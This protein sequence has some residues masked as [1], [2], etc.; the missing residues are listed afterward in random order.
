MDVMRTAF[1]VLLAAPAAAQHYDAAVD[2]ASQAIEIAAKAG[3]LAVDAAVDA[4]MS[5]TNPPPSVRARVR[6]IVAAE[7]LIPPAERAAI[8]AKESAKADRE[9]LPALAPLA[10]RA[11]P[12]VGLPLAEGRANALALQELLFDV[13]IAKDRL[14]R[15]WRLALAEREDALADIEAS[16]APARDDARLAFASN[17]RA[18]RID[19]IRFEA[20]GLFARVRAYKRAAQA[21]AGP[22]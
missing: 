22:R 16:R 20:N 17:A 12:L 7:K 15:K 5:V 21:S 18:E 13:S 4:V 2:A 3:P 10:A 14:D 8:R 19:E 9:F 1:L 6:S 11:E